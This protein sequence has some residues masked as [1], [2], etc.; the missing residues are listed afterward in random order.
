MQYALQDDDHGSRPARQIGNRTNCFDICDAVLNPA[1]FQAVSSPRKREIREIAAA[2][3]PIP[4]ILATEG[5]Q[6]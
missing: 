1:A 4:G 2:D 3:F 5:A 6:Q